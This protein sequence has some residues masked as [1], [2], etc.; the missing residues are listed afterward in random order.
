MAFKPISL[1][2]YLF[3]I[4]IYI[5]RDIFYKSAIGASYAVD[6]TGLY[7]QS[8]LFVYG[9]FNQELKENQ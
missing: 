6:E 2:L 7:G 9:L 3:K 8:A 4:I 1:F 5:A